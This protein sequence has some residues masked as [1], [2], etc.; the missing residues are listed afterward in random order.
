MEY[1][2]EL[3]QIFGG[4]MILPLEETFFLLLIS[5]AASA[6]LKTLTLL[7][8]QIKTKPNRKERKT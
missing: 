4:K 7:T 5:N 1:L 6:C 2:L 3:C 8:I